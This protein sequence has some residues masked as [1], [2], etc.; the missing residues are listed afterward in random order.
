MQ[1][2]KCLASTAT[3]PVNSI[4]FDVQGKNTSF[5][6]CLCEE[7]HSQDG[8]DTTIDA[9]TKCITESL[10]KCK[11]LVDDIPDGGLGTNALYFTSAL[12][13]MCSNKKAAVVLSNNPAFLLPP[14]NTAQ[15][16][17][18]V[19]VD[20][21]YMTHPQA[22]MSIRI[23]GVKRRS[24]LG[25]ESQTILGLVLRLGVP[26]GSPTVTRTFQAPARRSPSDIKST[27]AGFR[28]TLDTYQSKCNELVKAL[29]VSSGADS[30]QKVC[31]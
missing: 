10:V 31:R 2:A 25:L 30:R 20:P 23:S 9:V 17:Q 8:L 19:K 22:A 24:G 28:R 27:Q 14:P 12:R 18:V 16:V 3:D 5:Y 1:L 4:T 21:P 15:A 11:S 26:P 13:E 7:L 6:A 29:L